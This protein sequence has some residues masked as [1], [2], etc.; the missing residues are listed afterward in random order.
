MVVYEQKLR[1]AVIQKDPN[2]CLSDFKHSILAST[3]RKEEFNAH[4]FNK[5]PSSYYRVR[6]K[7]W[8]HLNSSLENLS[9]PAEFPSPY[10]PYFHFKDNYSEYL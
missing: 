2:L 7:S 3:S 4:P 6:D 9:E 1:L 5:L 10:S 8:I